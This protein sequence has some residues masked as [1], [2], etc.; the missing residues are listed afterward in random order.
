M[1]LNNEL[2]VKERTIKRLIQESADLAQKSFRKGTQCPDP[3]V[4]REMGLFTPK[5]TFIQR[6]FTL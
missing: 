4:L 2:K 5:K 1:F 6:L 3:S